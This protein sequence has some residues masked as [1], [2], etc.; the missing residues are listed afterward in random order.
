[1][2]EATQSIEVDYELSDSPERVW[3][4][5][6][7]PKLLSQWLMVNDIKP[8]VGHRFTFQATP[9]PGQWDGRVDCEVLAVEPHKLLS[10]SWKGGS[11]QLEGYGG[12]LDTVVTWT[13]RP[14]PKGGTLLHLSHSGFTA[15]NQY[16]FDNMGKGW[17]G[18]LDSR[19]RSVLEMS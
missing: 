17:R 4:A 11:D 3:R 13:L 2:T 14:S 16:A 8:V 12:K 18:P 5:L 10:Y 7:D 9:I 1:M 15:K 19:I 6:T